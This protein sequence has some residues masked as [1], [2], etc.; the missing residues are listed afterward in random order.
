MQYGIMYILDIKS[1]HLFYHLKYVILHIS[2]MKIR[3]KFYSVKMEFSIFYI[4][5]CQCWI[6][7]MK[8]WTFCISLYENLYAEF[9]TWNMVFSILHIWKSGWWSLHQ[10]WKSLYFTDENHSFG[11]L[12]IWRTNMV[13]EL[14]LFHKWKYVHHCFFFHEIWNSLYFLYQNLG[15]NTLSWKLDF[16]RV[17]IWRSE[18]R[19]PYK[20]YEITVFC[21]NQWSFMYWNISS[22]FVSLCL[23]HVCVHV[24]ACVTCGWMCV[25]EPSPQMTWRWKQKNMRCLTTSRGCRRYPQTRGDWSRH[26]CGAPVQGKNEQRMA[27]DNSG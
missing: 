25:H 12:Q 4:F 7:L 22:L 23:A 20:K 10:I 17:H 5:K 16:C 27:S 19:F 15:L 14:S 26:L 8:Y 18:W 21:M 6:Y 13:L 9:L 2:Y 24:C 3:V 11:F 1:V